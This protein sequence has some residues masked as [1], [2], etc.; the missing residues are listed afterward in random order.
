MG[1]PADQTSIMCYWPPGSI[2]RDGRPIT[3]GTDRDPTDFA[4]AGRIYPRAG[5]QQV[6]EED[7]E[8]EY[9]TAAATVPPS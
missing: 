7:W 8:G 9:A 5:H 2:T 6:E 3:G 4:F 1:T